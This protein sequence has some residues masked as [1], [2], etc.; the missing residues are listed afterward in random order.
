MCASAGHSRSR[1]VGRPDP[2]S[3]GYEWCGTYVTRSEAKQ[4]HGR[5]SVSVMGVLLSAFCQQPRA[6]RTFIQT[7]NQGSGGG[8]C[9]V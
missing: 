5:L 4:W 8:M 7:V 6:S 1:A 9:A 3:S 2:N